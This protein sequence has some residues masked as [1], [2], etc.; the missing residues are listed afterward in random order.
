MSGTALA[1]CQERSF[2]VGLCVVGSGLASDQRR[3]AR[4]GS[5]VA[6][7]V[8]CSAFH[9]SPERLV[10]WKPLWGPIVCSLESR[11]PGFL[12][13]DNSRVCC[14]FSSLTYYL[15]SA[16]SVGDEFDII[17]AVLAVRLCNFPSRPGDMPTFFCLR[18]PLANKRE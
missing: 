13:Y 8:S 11:P 15:A 1:R 16:Q 9:G 3:H 7:D 2:A 10:D 18:F 14:V 6:I 4:R 5:F 17:R 12:V